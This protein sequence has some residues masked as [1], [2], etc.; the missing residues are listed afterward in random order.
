M[1]S[2]DETFLYVI[3]TQGASVSA[4]HFNKTNGKMYAGCTSGPLTG[5]SGNYSY[6]VGV[7][8]INST[9]GNGGGVYVAEF[10]SSSAIAV[11]PLT[12]SG[13]K[14]TLQEATGSPVLDPNT[15][16]L[17]SIGTYPPRSF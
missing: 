6:L 7:G 10:G 17:L 14:C 9:T 1:L 2:P 16:G 12:V 11:V 8:L 4:I 15:P 3:N 5:Q 13:A